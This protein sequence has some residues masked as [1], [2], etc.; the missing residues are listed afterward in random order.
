MR[1]KKGRRDAAPLGYRLR[2]LASQRPFIF[3][4]DVV[5]NRINVLV[6]A[7]VDP[8]NREHMQAPATG[9]DRSSTRQ[10]IA[11]LRAGGLRSS[12]LLAACRRQIRTYRAG[13]RL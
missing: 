3:S 1:P 8:G 5:H 9:I 13:G 12:S 4:F 10:P 7:G 2:G 11:A 6:A